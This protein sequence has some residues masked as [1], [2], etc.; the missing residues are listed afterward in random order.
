MIPA[1]TLAL[2][3]ASGGVLNP[4]NWSTSTY[5]IA[6]A[7]VLLVHRV[8]PSAEKW[9]PRLGREILLIIP[10]VFLYFAVRGMVDAHEREPEALRNADYLIRLQEFLGISHEQTIQSWILS[11]DTLVTLMNWI[12]VWGHWPVVVGTIVWLTI[13]RPDTHHIYRNAF[14]L[15]GIIAMAIFALYPMA[16]PRLIPDLGFVDTI[17]QQSQSYRVLQPP[18]LTNPFAAMPSLHL[19]WNLLIGIAIVREARLPIARAFGYVMPIGMFLAIVLTGNH[20]F[21]DGVVGGLLVVGSLIAARAYHQ[22]QQRLQDRVARSLDTRSAEPQLDGRVALS[23]AGSSSASCPG[24]PDDH[25]DGFCPG[26][27]LYH[28]QSRTRG[29][30]PSS[31]TCAERCIQTSAYSP[32]M[33]HQARPAD[34]KPSG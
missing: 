11:S 32:D 3:Q 23:L 10:A 28:D 18:A 30:A 16:P 9:R 31:Q 7:I 34:R 20:F 5:L 19:G 4:F 21:L 6:I 29:F 8:M 26:I 33:L 25:P 14:M 15:S 24:R 27:T 12:Y 13:W 2:L 1:S 22:Q 17:T